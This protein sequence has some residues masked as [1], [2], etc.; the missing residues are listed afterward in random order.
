MGTPFLVAL[1]CIGLAL[2]IFMGMTRVIAEAGTATLRAPMIAPDFVLYGLGSS[3]VGPTGAF[4]LCLTYIWTAEVRSFV[5]ATCANAL[6]LVNEMEPSIRRGIFW[7]IV[8]ALLSG[9][10]GSFW[11]IFHMA[12]QHG[13]VNLSDWFFNSAPQQL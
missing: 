1:L 2:A 5:M 4:N 13:G 11:M 9:A 10:L 3:L 12:Y 7:G 6:K 8:L